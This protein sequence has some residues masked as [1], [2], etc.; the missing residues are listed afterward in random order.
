MIDQI[1][2]AYSLALNHPVYD[3]YLSQLFEQDPFPYLRFLYYVGELFEVEIAVELG[4]CTG[5]GTAHLAASCDFVYTIDPEPHGAF[6]ENTKPYSNIEFIQTRSDDLLT[7]D[8]FESGSVDLCFVDSVHTYDY[9]MKEIEL[10]TPKMK[11][12]GI[13]LLDDL[14]LMPGALEALPFNIKGYLEGLH[15]KGFGYAFI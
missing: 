7:L 8:K 12:G 2:Q 5:R 11:P 13:F 1:K 10:W 4:T 6:I 9:F 14:D 15:I 3:D